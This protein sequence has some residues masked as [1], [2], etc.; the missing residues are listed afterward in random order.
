MQ[1]TIPQA[2][3]ACLV[4]LLCVIAQMLGAPFTLLGLLNWDM[5]ASRNSSNDL[6]LSPTFRLISP[7]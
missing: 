4:V 6:N 2:T 5:L 7:E 3:W 1:P